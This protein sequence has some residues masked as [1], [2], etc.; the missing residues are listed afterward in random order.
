MKSANAGP[1]RKKPLGGPRIRYIGGHPS[2][3]AF[4]CR[5]RRGAWRA[6]NGLSAEALELLTRNPQFEV[7]AA[8]PSRRKTAA[9]PP[10]EEGDDNLP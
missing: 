7:L 1:K 2:A 5:F 10:N 3:L 9:S 4:G 6:F 8:G